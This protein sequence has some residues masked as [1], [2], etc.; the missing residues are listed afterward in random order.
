MPPVLVALPDRVTIWLTSTVWSPPAATVGDA[1]CSCT[2]M[3]A[4]STCICMVCVSVTVR[5][6]YSVV[7]E[8]G[9]VKV[10][11]AVFGLF[12]VSG[13]PGAVSE[14]APSTSSHA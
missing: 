14:A 4:R 7:G 3:V 9:A 6:K 5:R 8:V 1:T 13:D 11:A 12:S 2:V 10:G